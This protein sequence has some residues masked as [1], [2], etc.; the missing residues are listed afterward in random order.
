MSKQISL[1]DVAELM[2]KGYGIEAVPEQPIDLTPIVSALKDLVEKR[3]DIEPLL[4]AINELTQAVRHININIPPTDLKP[5][6][7]AV[8]LIK[9]A[10][11][12][13]PVVIEKPRM[14]KF[15]VIRDNRQLIENI[16]VTPLDGLNTS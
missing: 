10:P 6:L 9:Q 12:S 16:T 2:S 7:D 8:R 3:P 11:A 14:Y 5:V 15:Q 1:T 4:A 13:A